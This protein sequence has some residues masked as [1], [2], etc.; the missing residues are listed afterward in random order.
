MS[1]AMV[2]YDLFKNDIT[3]RPYVPPDH[4]GADRTPQA[5]LL[6]VMFNGGLNPS[7]LNFPRLGRSFGVIV[8][9]GMRFARLHGIEFPIQQEL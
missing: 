5:K 1:S 2:A 4:G 7:T 9:Q 8:N 6:L 3:S